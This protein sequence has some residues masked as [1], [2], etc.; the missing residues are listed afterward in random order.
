MNCNIEI[1]LSIEKESN[2]N[3]CHN[4]FG[5]DNLHINNHIKMVV[6]SLHSYVILNDYV[7]NRGGLC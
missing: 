7:F 1:S 5:I 6:S 3:I 4:S 2:K